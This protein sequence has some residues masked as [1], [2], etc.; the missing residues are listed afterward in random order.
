M[1]LFLN[2]SVF[3]HTLQENLMA[4]N[5]S[6]FLLFPDTAFI[7]NILSTLPQLQIICCIYPPPP[8]ILTCVI[9]TLNRKSKSNRYHTRYEISGYLQAV[10][11]LLLRPFSQ[12]CSP[13]SN[14]L[15]SKDLAG[16]WTPGP[17]CPQVQATSRQTWESV[18]FSGMG[19]NCGN[20]PPRWPYQP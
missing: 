6:H 15:P 8:H 20:S 14:L 13:R 16:I 7:D 10:V 17:E 4:Y 11:R 1:Q 12:P 2:P 19:N 9:S 18:G 5:A 3:Y